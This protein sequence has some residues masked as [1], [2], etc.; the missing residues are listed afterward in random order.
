MLSSYT[1]LVHLNIHSRVTQLL[2]FVILIIYC[3]HILKFPPFFLP[4]CLQTNSKYKYYKFVLPPT[5]IYFYTIHFLTVFNLFWIQLCLTQAT[6]SF[7]YCTD[8]ILTNPAFLT[9]DVNTVTLKSMYFLFVFLSNSLVHNKLNIMKCIQ[10]ITISLF[11][12]PL[13]GLLQ[14]EIVHGW[15]TTLV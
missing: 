11:F 7:V 10:L 14:F 5:F 15:P 8:F 6:L 3:R 1:K 9:C 12:L 2:A 13:L 4:I